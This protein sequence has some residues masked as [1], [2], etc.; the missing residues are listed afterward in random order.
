M[1]KIN[2]AELLKD[3]PKGMEL[4][5]TIFE[6]VIFEEVCTRCSFPIR[7][8]IDGYTESLTE[9]GCVSYKDTAKCVIFPKGKT[10]WK[11]FQKP[12]KNG[13]VLYIDC[14]DNGDTNKLYQYIFILKEII[15]G[16]IYCYCYIDEANA[17]EKFEI[18][19][20]ADQ[21]YN[22]RFAT[23]EE[24]EKLFDAIKENGY[25]WNQETK[26]LEE[27][28]KFKVGDRITNG[29]VSITIDYIDDNYY[30]EVGRNI[31]TRVFIKNQD[32]WELDKFNVT[33]LKPFDKVLVRNYNSEKWTANL[34]GFFGKNMVYPYSCIGN[35]VHQCVPYENNEHLLGTTNDCDDYYKTW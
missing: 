19:C 24:K 31:A 17:C 25:K 12:F 33:T 30:Y 13:D 32:E 20:L 28:P 21:R 7:I 34:F 29:K 6:N 26:T 9:Y 5:C 3:C 11:G 27:L 1:E 4:D 2:I 35:C 15:A 14:N 22:P 8:I 16:K 23:E 18:C 10:T